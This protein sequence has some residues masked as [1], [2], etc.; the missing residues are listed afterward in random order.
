MKNYIYILALLP[1]ISCTKESKIS[2]VI[3][4]QDSAVINPGDSLSK[5]IQSSATKNLSK[6]ETLRILNNEILSTLKSKDFIKFSNYI[7]PE[8]GI[9]FSMY[10]HLDSKKDKHFTK[11]EFIKYV[12]TNIKFTWGEKDGTG[13]KLVLSIKDYMLEWVF[14]K[15]FMQGEYHL[16]SFK[17]RGNSINNLRE[18]YPTFDFTENY[19]PGSEEYGEMDWNSLRFVFDK[20][21][22]QYYLVAVVNN[23]WTI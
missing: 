1:L 2:S 20:Y 19:L 10:A 16:N 21:E 9:T 4:S 12:P 5:T 3:S 17:G 18:I 23:S 14:R 7:H 8:K 6:D 11:Q 22:G 15:D 13:N